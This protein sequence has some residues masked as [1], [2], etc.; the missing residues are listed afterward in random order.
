MSDI[1]PFEGRKIR[2]VWDETRETWL[3]SVVDAVA[4][5]TD[6]PNPRP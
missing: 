2:T 6:S 1:T 5:L 4:A 3:F